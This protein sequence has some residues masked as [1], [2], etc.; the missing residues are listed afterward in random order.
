MLLSHRI[1]TCLNADVVLSLLFKGASWTWLSKNIWKNN[2]KIN[3]LAKILNSFTDRV[4]NFINVPTETGHK[5]WLP[6][7]SV[8][9][10]FKYRQFVLLPTG[11]LERWW[12]NNVNIFLECRSTAVVIFVYNSL[13]LNMCLF[14]NC[15]LILR[16]KE[17]EVTFNTRE[18]IRTSSCQSLSWGL[19]LLICQNSSNKYYYSY[20]YYY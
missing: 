8:C 4:L 15:K 11:T 7:K 14:V 17:E 12:E 3:V 13:K 5:Q 2:I 10:G 9:R 6:S 16:K 20:F 19:V 1:Q 18:H